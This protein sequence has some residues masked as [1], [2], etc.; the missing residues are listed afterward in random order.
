EG[1]EA[2]LRSVAVG[3]DELMLAPERRQRLRR[4]PH[5]LPHILRG[6]RLTAAQQGVAAQGYQDSHEG[7]SCSPH[8][9]AAEL[10]KGE[11]Y[12]RGLTPETSRF[13]SRAGTRILQREENYRVDAP[14]IAS[15]FRS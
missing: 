9:K 3:N 6:H 14:P 5:V 11:V 8:P 12:S 10:G 4:D 7:T 15:G 13:R 1:E 2:H